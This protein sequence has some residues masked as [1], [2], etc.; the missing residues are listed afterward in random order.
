MPPQQRHRA[1]KCHERR[2]GTR[3]RLDIVAANHHAAERHEFA[4]GRLHQ[5][6]IRA[7]KPPVERQRSQGSTADRGAGPIRQ[8]VGVPGIGGELH[9]AALIEIIDDLRTGLEIGVTALVRR[10]TNHCLEIS[11]RVSDTIREAGFTTLPSAR[12][13]DRTGRRRAGAADAIGFLTQQHVKALERAHQGC[14]HAG[15][16]SADNKHVDLD[17]GGTVRHAWGGD[18][19][20]PLRI[21][22]T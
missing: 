6:E 19:H 21:T 22:T 11:L 20:F 13:P 17:R 9:L 5:R 7:E 8:I 18:G 15:G 2:K 1:T 16:A 14:R 3:K 10:G 4:D 12:H